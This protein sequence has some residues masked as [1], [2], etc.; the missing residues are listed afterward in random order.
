MRA[1]LKEN[2]Q[3]NINCTTSSPRATQRGW[4]FLWVGGKERVRNTDEKKSRRENRN[5]QTKRNECHMSNRS[6][7]NTWK[8]G[9][10]HVR[11]RE[12]DNQ[13]KSAVQ[14]SESY[15]HHVCLL[16]QK[17][18]GGVSTLVRIKLP[19][20]C[21]SP[22]VNKSPRLTW[23]VVLSLTSAVYV[24]HERYQSHFHETRSVRSTVW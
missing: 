16:K 13:L 19:F 11:Q 2:L 4:I 5:T 1:Q 22:V 3:K 18:E 8:K 17:I 7:T 6:R 21:A 15:P 24:I 23:F 14:L 9:S 10:E 20:L 12:T